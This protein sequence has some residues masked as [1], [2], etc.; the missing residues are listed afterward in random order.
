MKHFPW[1]LTLLITLSACAHPAAAPTAGAPSPSIRY[2]LAFRP[3]AHEIIVGMEYVAQGSDADV[4]FT[5]PVWAP[6]YYLIV[7]YPKNLYDFAACQTDGMP[8]RWEKVGKNHWRVEKPCNDTLRVQYRVFADERSVAECRVEHDVAF[9]PGNGVFMYPEGGKALPVEV[10]FTLPEHWHTVATA[11]D[12]CEG[13]WIAPDFDVLYDSPFLLGNP[14]VRTFEQEGHRYTFAIEAPEGFDASP[15]AADW[16]KGV[17][18]ATQ[19]FGDVPYDRYVLLLLGAGRGGLE[20]QSCQADYTTDN[21]QFADRASYI[22]MLTFLTHEYFH[23]YNVKA[24]RPI[25]LGPFDYNQENY[26]P[27]LW[28]S[29]GFTC[30]YESKLLARAGVLT[31]EE[32]LE[33]LAVYIRDL[34]STEGRH[35]MSLRQSSYDIWLNFFNFAANHSDVTLS[36]YVK[37]PVVGLLFDC[38]Y[39]AH[40]TSLDALMRLLYDRYYRDLQRGFTEQEFWEAA[41]EIAAGTEQALRPYVDTTLD[42]PYATFLAPVGLQYDGATGQLSRL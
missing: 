12:S 3:D 17:H 26:T 8:L 38:W 9:V 25:E 10:G 22:S 41:E 1:L 7:D 13:R 29:E 16:L 24:I 40:G 14:A 4:T 20:H 36:Y 37:G 31:D 34:E 21:W 27:M 15:L 42:I 32:R 23:N 33:E 5:L 30:Y 39:E 11:L 28:V 18:E 6:G 2:Q 19:L 35:H